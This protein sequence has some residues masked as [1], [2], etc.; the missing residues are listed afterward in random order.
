[1]N[2]PRPS[3]PTAM[4]GAAAVLAAGALAVSITTAVTSPSA[5]AASPS[6]YRAP[7]RPELSVGVSCVP[8]TNTGTATVYVGAHTSSA[9]WQAALTDAPAD[10]AG[11][12][13][14]HP[15]R[16]WGKS[17]SGW[18]AP[19]PITGRGVVSLASDQ[20]WVAVGMG[21]VPYDCHP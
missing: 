2:T 15:F 17:Q 4:A 10:G 11:G 21:T 1:M 16:E 8:G 13:A 20:T 6:F 19:Y 14:V 9:P 3:R 18:T 5:P 7:G 12:G